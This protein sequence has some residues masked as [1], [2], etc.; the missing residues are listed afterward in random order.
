MLPW[1]R[2]LPNEVAPLQVAASVRSVGVEQALRQSVIARVPMLGSGEVA[3]D[4]EH[5][6]DEA[7]EA[8][9]DAPQD[10]DL[11]VVNLGNAQRTRRDSLHPSQNSVGH[12]HHHGQHVESAGQRVGEQDVL[13]LVDVAHHDDR[14]L[15]VLGPEQAQVQQVVEVEVDQVLRRAHREGGADL[16]QA[17]LEQVDAHESKQHQPRDSHVQSSGSD[18]IG[19][20]DVPSPLE[21][22]YDV[23]KPGKQHVLF[24]DVGVEAEAGPVQAHV[25]VSVP[26]EIVGSQENVQVAHSVHN[27]EEDQEERTPGEADT[28][29]GELEVASEEDGAEDL[30]H[31]SA[32]HEP[33]GLD[34]PAEA[35]SVGI[36]EIQSALGALRGLSAGSDHLLLRGRCAGASGRGAASSAHGADH[37]VGRVLLQHIRRVDHVELRTGVLASECQD[38]E[39]TAGVVLQEAGDVEHLAVQHNPAI[40]L[41][42]M[43]GNFLHCVGPCAHSRRTRGRRG[44]RRRRSTRGGLGSLGAARRPASK[45]PQVSVHHISAHHVLSA[46]AGGDAAE[47]HTVQQ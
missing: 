24:N 31:E 47:G 29:V 14:D 1:G 9:D 39:L 43:L 21:P 15:G 46:V 22:D 20:G 16:G 28:I 3:E 33:H 38:G 12:E 42:G 23:Q 17:V 35:L 32:H 30:H 7:N 18:G 36:D 4:R 45:L 34:A 11:H 10:V 44:R 2:H 13:E 8:D 37:G 19:N 6:V 25:E 26:V 5:K 41:G 40:I 27:Q